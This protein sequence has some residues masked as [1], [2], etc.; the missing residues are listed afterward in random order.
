MAADS[1]A[2]LPA[3]PAV[4]TPVYA[5]VMVLTFWLPRVPMYPHRG[6]VVPHQSH[7]RALDLRHPASRHRR[8]RTF[9]RRHT[10]CCRSTVRPG[11]RLRSRCSSRRSPTSPRRSSCPSR[12]S[13]GA[14]RSRRRSPSTAKPGTDAMHQIAAQGRERFRQGFWIVI[15]PEGTRIPRRHPGEVQDRR[16]AARDR[17]RRADTAGRAQRRLSVAEG[18][19]R[20]APRNRDDLVRQAD[21][22]EGQ[23]RADADRGK[24]RRG[25]RPK[26][27]GSGDPDRSR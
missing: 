19:L 20:E 8:A 27:R 14:S 18:R 23:G 15:Y 17:A 10:S 12:S 21:S 3:L 22:A 1:R 6:V 5:V 7:R 9:R 25:S 26:S 16:C 2:R 4:V 24:P 11:R 13:A